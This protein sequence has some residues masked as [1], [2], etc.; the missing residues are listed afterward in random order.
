MKK[1]TIQN[2]SASFIIEKT[3][4]KILVKFPMLSLLILGRCFSVVPTTQKMSLSQ[5]LFHDMCIAAEY[6]QW[7]NERERDGSLL[8]HVENKKRLFCLFQ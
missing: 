4:D 6:S 7:Q 2:I 3:D 1:S 8:F 5:I